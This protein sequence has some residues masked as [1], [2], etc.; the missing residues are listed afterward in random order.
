MEVCITNGSYCNYVTVPRYIYE[1]RRD[2]FVGGKPDCKPIFN[3]IPCHVDV[4]L[5]HC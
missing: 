4:S 5:T 3:N 2:V 1:A